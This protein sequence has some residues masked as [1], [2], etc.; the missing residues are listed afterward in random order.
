M[1]RLLL[2]LLH[3]LVRPSLPTLSTLSTF[4][5]FPP[6]HPPQSLSSLTETVLSALCLCYLLVLTTTA[7]MLTLYNIIRAFT[8][9]S[10]I[11]TELREKKMRRSG[12]A[13]YGKE[14]SSS[15]SSS[16]SSA[17]SPTKA[18]SM[19][20][21]SPLDISRELGKIGEKRLDDDEFNNQLPFEKLHEN[22]VVTEATPIKP[23]FSLSNSILM[24]IFHMAVAYGHVLLLLRC[25]ELYHYS[26][27]FY[28]AF[29][30]TFHFA[31]VILFL[32]WEKDTLDI[33]HSNNNNKQPNQM[34]NEEKLQYQQ[35]Q[36]SNC[37]SKQQPTKKIIAE[38]SF[39]RPADFF[40]KSTHL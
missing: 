16:S 36:H 1:D 37:Y 23:H 25:W 30:G 22:Y 12:E 19:S 27:S 7:V 5:P 40:L 6:L 32:S 15:S 26:L 39:P 10:V 17:A 33:D 13:I 20:S 18:S 29:I 35:Q 14:Q 28:A 34:N 2:P 9:A 38:N 3:A 21:S 8:F 11:T 4:S 31:P 24:F